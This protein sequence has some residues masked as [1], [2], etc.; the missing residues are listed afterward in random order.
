MD[1]LLRVV[2][3]LIV[4]LNQALDELKT[5]QIENAKLMIELCK[6]RRAAWEYLKKLKSMYAVPQDEQLPWEADECR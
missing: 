2:D 4:D 3:S 6:A 1:D 5:T